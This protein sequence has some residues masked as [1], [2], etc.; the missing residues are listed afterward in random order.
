MKLLADHVSGTLEVLYLKGLSRVTDAGLEAICRSC[1]HLRVLDLSQVMT[2]SD[3]GGRTIQNLTK[4]RALFLRDNYQLTNDSLD[5]ITQ[6]CTKLNQLTLWGMIRLQHLKF[7]GGGS[8]TMTAFNNGRLI[9]LNL[10]GCH[11]LQDDAAQALESMSNLR[12]LIVSE[13]HRLTDTFIDTL[14]SFPGLQ[15]LHHL[16]LRYLRRIT[17]ASVLAIAKNMRQL[18]SL[19]LSFCSE[20]TAMGIYRL[21]ESSGSHLA[22][23]R[24]KCCRPKLQIGQ[25]D[26]SSDQGRTN[27][28]RDHAGHWILNALRPPP[29]SVTQHSLCVLDVRLCGGQK[30]ANVPYPESDPFVAGMS[31]LGFEQKVPGFFSRPA[32]YCRPREAANVEGS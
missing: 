14:V 28:R 2:I 21:L 13:C 24:L 27:N 16:H 5:A 17:D 26:P 20:V 31:R 30:D 9:I 12:T 10:W 18:Y 32:T 1:I 25:W 23:L 7:D 29:H 8:G 3:A 15:G 6:R 4:L 22:E 11:S 19:D